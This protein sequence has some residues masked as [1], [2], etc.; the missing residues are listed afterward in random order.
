GVTL[1]MNLLASF[2]LLLARYA[3]Q[4]RV[5]VGF[6]IAGRNRKETE[7]LIGFFVNTLVIVTDLS[8][9]PTVRDLLHRVREKALGAYAHQEAPFEKLVEEL[10][11]ERS[12]NRHPLFQVMLAHLNYQARTLELPGLT[13]AAEP[14]GADKANFDLTLTSLEEDGLLYGSLEY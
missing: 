7:P 14:V 11:P 2:Q 9:N 8:G 6:P 5:A 3:G 1:F 10:Q 4:D 12:L 13:I